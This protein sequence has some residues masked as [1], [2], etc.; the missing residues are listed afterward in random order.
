MYKDITVGSKVQVIRYGS[1]FEGE[2]GYIKK[3]EMFR[4]QVLLETFSRP[5]WFS[6]TDVALTE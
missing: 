5:M 1:A 2:I 4:V 3:T 6:R